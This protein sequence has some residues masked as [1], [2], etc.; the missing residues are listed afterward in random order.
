[1]VFG[2]FQIVFV[3]ITGTV[4]FHLR[5]LI[6][7]N[8]HR[9]MRYIVTILH[10]IIGETDLHLTVSFGVVLTPIQGEVVRFAT[11]SK[12]ILDIGGKCQQC[13]TATANAD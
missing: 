8:N 5:P 3:R 4:C 1:M 6:Q 10:V 11:L 2:Q 7:V 12:V 9:V 13:C